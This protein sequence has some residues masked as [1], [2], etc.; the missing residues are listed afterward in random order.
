M[1]SFS[2]DVQAQHPCCHE[3]Q[4]L[5]CVSLAT[6]PRSSPGNLVMRL[7]LVGYGKMGQL[8]EQMALAQGIEIA[9]RIDVGTGDWSAPADVAG[10]FSTPG[11]RTDNFPRYVQRKLPVVIGTTGWADLMALFRQEAERAGLG[12]GGSA[13]IFLGGEFFH[14][15]V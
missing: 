15:N 14:I 13:K 5:R 4:R 7:L 11:A 9:S 2:V 6:F 8:V 12:V 10:D 3:P 1:R